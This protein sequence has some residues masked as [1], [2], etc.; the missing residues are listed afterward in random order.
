M[1]SVTKPKDRAE[2]RPF[3]TIEQATVF[4]DH[5]N[6]LVFTNQVGNLVKIAKIRKREKSRTHKKLNNGFI[7]DV[8]R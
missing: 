5:D 2:Q 4:P 1:E 6:G 3:L 8:T 7:G